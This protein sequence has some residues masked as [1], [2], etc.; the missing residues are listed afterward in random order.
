MPTLDYFKAHPLRLKQKRDTMPI[1]LIL[2]AEYAACPDRPK[3]HP[4]VGAYIHYGGVELADR[5][6]ILNPT[7]PP[8]TWNKLASYWNQ[9]CGV[10]CRQLLFYTW[11]II[12]KEQRHGSSNMANKAFGANSGLWTPGQKLVAAINSGGDYDAILEA[13]GACPVG[14][15]LKAVV[16]HYNTGGWTGAF[17]GKKWGFIAEQVQKYFAG[18]LSAMMAAD[19]MWT[20][21]HNTGPIFNKGFYF[22]H[23]NTGPLME[24]LNAQAKGSVF[25]VSMSAAKN[26]ELMH[27]FTSFVA[28]AVSAIKTV[29][30]DFTL[31]ATLTADQDDD[32]DPDLDEGTT[33]VNLGTIPLT[34]HTR[35][36]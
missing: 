18:E 33:K 35:E 1:S 25:Q 32:E 31:G 9:S 36:A 8:D 22:H 27:P 34:L 12:A 10:V 13:G 7:L 30:P 6:S 5:L 3:V 23:H 2:K 24:V 16:A 28:L 20:L 11:K 15:Y 17:G 29:D 14:D 21:V 4:H 26:P 19:R